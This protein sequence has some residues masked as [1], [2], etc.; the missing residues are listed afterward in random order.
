M[1]VE[2]GSTTV[3][4][5]LPTVSLRRDRIPLSPMGGA[6]QVPCSFV[7]HQGESAEI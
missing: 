4:L 7:G 1:P 6:D 5:S 3:K 2:K